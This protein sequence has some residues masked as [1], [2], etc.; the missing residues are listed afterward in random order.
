MFEVS[1][2]T[3][4]LTLPI[5][6]APAAANE[7][8]MRVMH[9]LSKPDGSPEGLALSLQ[10]TDLHVRVAG[11]VVMPTQVRVV[12]RP[13]RWEFGLSI[14]AASNE[15]IFPK[16]EGTLSL[17]PVG[18]HAVELWLQ[19]HYAPPFGAIG[20]LLDRTVLRHAAERSLTSFLR[21]IADDVIADAKEHYD[22]R[23]L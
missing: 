7:S 9:A 21:R 15:G 2:R 14:R 12:D 23:I 10:L 6:M 19:G 11:E 18:K 5:A 20:A 8:L 1:E 16:F 22:L 17:T 4:E 13:A 3:I